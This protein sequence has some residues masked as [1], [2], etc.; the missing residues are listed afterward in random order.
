MTLRVGVRLHG[1]RLGQ[2]RRTVASF[3]AAISKQAVRGSPKKSVGSAPVAE[4]F[5]SCD[6]SCPWRTWMALA[7]C[8][9]F[10]DSSEACAGCVLRV[11][12]REHVKA[13]A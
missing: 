8:P 1:S 12:E 6:L 4:P 3:Q 11:S 9:A 7:S 2:R 13:G 10:R 5:S